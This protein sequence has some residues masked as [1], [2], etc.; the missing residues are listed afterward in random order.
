[1]LAVRGGGGRRVI[2]K[3]WSAPAGDGDGFIDYGAEETAR[4]LS[5]ED[6]TEGELADGG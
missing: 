3:L 2:L 1:M 5:G 6:W 4:A